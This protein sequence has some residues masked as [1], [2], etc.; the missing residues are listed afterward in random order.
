MTSVIPIVN[1]RERL[2]EHD[3]LSDIAHAVINT[4]VSIKKQLKYHGI[5]IPLIDYFFLAEEDSLWILKFKCVDCD[6]QV[7]LFSGSLIFRYG[8]F[9]DARKSFIDLL[10][11]VIIR[12]SDKNDDTSQ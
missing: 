7:V 9:I 2:Y 1:E 6:F 3:T 10:N 4:V 11:I 12:N 5:I 8:L